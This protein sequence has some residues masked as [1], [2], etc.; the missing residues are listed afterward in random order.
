M[1]RTYRDTGSGARI[2][3]SGL[4]RGVDCV[5]GLEVRHNLRFSGHNRAPFR[6]TALTA[7]RRRRSRADGSAQ[8]V[9]AAGGAPPPPHRTAPTRRLTAV[10]GEGSSMATDYDTPRKTH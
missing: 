5:T 1:E 4:F 9:P 3:C 8:L 2:T 6:V 7:K 10:R